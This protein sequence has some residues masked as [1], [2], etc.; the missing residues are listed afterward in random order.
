MKFLIQKV[1]KAN[2]EVDGEVIGAIS[3]GL[4]VLI[5]IKEDDTKQSADKLIEKT[6]NMRLFT[7]DYKHFDLSVQ[8]INGS[9]LLVSQFTLYADCRKGRRPDFIKAASADQAKEIYNY[10]I[11]KF[12]ASGLQIATGKFQAK[13]LVNISNN[14]PVTIMLDSDNL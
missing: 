1:N 13:M 9:V 12:T 8:E 4:V 2:V 3:E 6:I 10:I 5:G 11:E 7:Q 14:G